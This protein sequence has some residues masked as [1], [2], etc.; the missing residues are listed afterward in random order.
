[1]QKQ[2]AHTGYHFGVRIFSLRQSFRDGPRKIEVAGSEIRFE[3]Q[4]EGPPN[5]TRRAFRLVRILAWR[6]EIPGVP[7][8]PDPSVDGEPI[9]RKRFGDGEKLALEFGLSIEKL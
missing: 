3:K 2:C 8:P 7:Q 1:M 5:S 9:G 4:P 6:A